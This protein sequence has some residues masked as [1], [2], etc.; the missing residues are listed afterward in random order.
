MYIT[1]SDISNR[2]RNKNTNIVHESNYNL[3][4]INLYTKNNKFILE[5]ANHIIT[6]WRSL[7]NDSTLAMIKAFDIFDEMCDNCTDQEIKKACNILIEGINKV[8]NTQ[9]LVNSIKYRNSRAKTRIYGKINKGIENSINALHH[10][11]DSI[12]SKISDVISANNSK[13]PANKTSGVASKSECYNALLNEAEKCY[14]CDRIIKNHNTLSKRFDFDKIISENYTSIN[15]L[16]DT[17]IEVCKLI[18]TYDTNFKNKYNT[19]LE[20][21]VYL[22][23]KAYLKCDNSV[24][25]EAVT[26]YFIF[27]SII[28]ESQLDDIDTVRNNSI[29]LKRDDFTCI[30]YLFPPEIN[31]DC[32]RDLK[33]SEMVN[34][35]GTESLLEGELKDKIKEISKGNPHEHENDEIKKMIEDFKDSCKD[36]K[37]ET[38]IMHL[39]ALA[40]KMYTKQPKHIIDGLPNFFS[41]IRI[42]ILVVSCAISPILAI[43]TAIT[44]YF[45]KQTLERKQCEKLVNKYK[46]EIETVKDKIEKQK[47]ERK[48]ENLEKYKSELEKDLKKIQEYEDNLYSE[49]ENDERKYGA[50]SDFE[51][52]DDFDFDFGDDDWDNFDESQ[53][54]NASSIILISSLME[55]IN[56]TAMVNDKQVD[57]IIY[58]NIYK[59]S[60]K[61]IDGITDFSI[62]V[63]MIIEKDKFK[64]VLTEYRDKLRESESSYDNYMRIDC[65]NENLY[66]LSNSTN[67]YNITN[68]TKGIIATLMWLD[69]ATKISNNEY[70]TEMNL[71]NTI[72]LATDR[73]KKTAVKLSTKD[74]QI[75]NSID[76]A[77]SSVSK[78]LEEALMNDSREAIIKGRILP[79]ASKTI[80][81][82][83]ATGAAW[84]INPA[85]AVIGAL[86][87]FACHKKLSAKERQ[88]VLDDIEIELKMCE[89]YLKQAEEKNDMKAIRQIEMTQ[90]N[91]QRQQQRI[92]YKMHVVYNDKV[93]NTVGEED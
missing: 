76:V 4:N 1:P 34:N 48:K 49:E 26:D 24:V 84:A 91:L 15:D 77:M 18:D 32:V 79:S 70:I 47:D 39:K 58:D 72:K 3:H 73:L 92:K 11:M 27:T 35:Y 88:L 19:A 28:S 30:D 68:D 31:T 51:F 63:P 6:N 55:S 16:Y 71:T 14:E 56:D 43:L 45:I 25:V 62:T 22:I 90:R 5:N 9:Q 2:I 65:I 60:N 61:T 33:I 67:P 20:E 53:Y 86:G 89:R 80:K 54:I 36:D 93:P 23:N 87:A 83:L 50:D 41:I 52:D 29:L 12:T 40:N 85:I 38:F 44:G 7:D 37:P 21:S 78:G 69:E 46:S 13:L 17:V 10:P 66:K 82:A 42:G 59:F 74:K 8:R 81:I 57:G 64:T 75:S